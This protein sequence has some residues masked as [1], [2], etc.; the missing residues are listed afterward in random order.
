MAEFHDPTVHGCSVRV[1]EDQGSEV[2]VVIHK[3]VQLLL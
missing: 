2:F 1:L 3:V